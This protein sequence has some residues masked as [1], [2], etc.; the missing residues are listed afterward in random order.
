MDIVKTK[1]SNHQAGFT[2][3]ELLVVIGLIGVLAAVAVARYD[4]HIAS[5]NRQQARAALLFAQQA[6]ERAHLQ[7]GTYVGAVLPA[8]QPN[9][10]FVITL[11]NPTAVTYTL[12]STTRPPAVDPDCGTL[13]IDQAGTRGATGP[14][15]AL[16]CWQ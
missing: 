10:P 16:A 4:D 11:V 12:Q 9:D 1:S 3:L 6:M 5:S 2:L 13:S 15:G 8:A 14:I 7:S